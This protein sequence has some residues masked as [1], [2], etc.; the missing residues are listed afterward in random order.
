MATPTTNS[1][2][3]TSVAISTNNDIAA[4]TF[5]SKWGGDLGTGVVLTYSFPSDGAI[6]VISYSSSDEPGVDNPSINLFPL[7]ANQQAAFQ[8]M[9]TAISNVADITFVQVADNTNTVG[10]IRVASTDAYAGT[11]TAA[12]AYFPPLVNQPNNPS[13]GDIWLNAD[14]FTSSESVEPGTIGFRTFLHET[15]H[16][17][18]LKHPNEASGNS[19]AR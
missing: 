4:L 3:T 2:P 7:D 16:A 9:F 8:E 11:S 10:E 15:L 1:V 13:S 12:L 17:L 19:T 18:G 14:S 6:F 5:G